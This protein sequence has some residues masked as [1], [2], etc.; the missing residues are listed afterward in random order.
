MA[1]R[2]PKSQREP[3]YLRVQLLQ[4]IERFEHELNCGDLRGRVVSLVPAF[5]ALRDLG[6]SLISK[7]DAATARDRIIFYLKAYPRVIIKGDELMV[8]AG[9]GEWARRVRELRVEQGWSII[10]GVTADE[11]IKAGDLNLHGLG[12]GSLMVDDYL[13]LDER[14]DRDAAFRWNSANTIR[15]K[16]IGVKEKLLEFLKLNVMRAVTG[17]ELRYVADGSTEWA[18]RIRELRTEEGWSISTRTTGRPDLPIG[19]YLLED[20]NQIPPHDRRIPDDVRGEVLARDNY[21]CCSCG[22]SHSIWNRSDPRHLQLHHVVHHA[23]G[24]QN[25]VD[26]LVTLCTRCHQKTHREDR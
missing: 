20:L 25:S 8:V 2:S 24:G 5:H 14:Q 12:C 4:L 17:E 13:L 15:K 3:E 6:S 16:K 22:W 26:N 19:V 9:I 1:R 10:T 18:R 21:S 11:M 7:T 23:R